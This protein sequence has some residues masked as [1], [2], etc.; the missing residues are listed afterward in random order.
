MKKLLSFITLAS[1]LLALTLPVASAG[2]ESSQIQNTV[3]EYL[4]N[5]SRNMLLYEDNQTTAYTVKAVLDD[6]LKTSSAATKNLRQY[7]FEDNK[8]LSIE[9]ILNR[10]AYVD[11]YVE[12]TKYL[13]QKQGITRDN[14]VLQYIFQNIKTSEDT[15][16]VKVK[17]WAS[18]MYTDDPL[19]NEPTEIVTSYSV[20][21]VKINSTWA[22]ADVESEYITEA[23][24]KI[25]INVSLTKHSIDTWITETQLSTLSSSANNS[26]INPTISQETPGIR[27]MTEEEASEFMS[28]FSND[29]NTAPFESTNASK[30]TYIHKT[31]LTFD[32][33]SALQYANTYW[34]DDI[35]NPDS[36]HTWRNKDVFFDYGNYG[37]DCQN[38]ASQLVYI[39]FGGTNDNAVV[40]TH[41]STPSDSTGSAI[42]YGDSRYTQNTSSFRGCSSFRNYATTVRNS[43]NESGLMT[44]TYTLASTSNPGTE[45][46]T[47]LPGSVVHVY[48]SSGNN[49]HA[50]FC[51]KT[52]G[53]TWSTVYYYSHSNSV[54]NGRIGDVSNWI[55][56]NKPIIIIK[57]TAFR[58]IVQNSCPSHVYTNYSDATCN[59]CGYNRMRIKATAPQNYGIVNLG[60]TITVGGRAVH[61]A[62]SDT[63]T[64]YSMTCY[65]MAMN[66]VTPSG[67][68]T[69]YEAL[70]VLSISKSVTF[71]E[72]GIYTFTV[73]GR[74]KNP[75]TSTDSA[76]HYIKFTVRVI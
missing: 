73:A 51:S 9:D 56:T 41:A 17:E 29:S 67:T 60:S 74:D 13:R 31:Y 7:N 75:S 63:D 6:D 37:G 34:N 50:I 5:L 52:T 39:G 1:M 8:V 2:N 48:G 23:D 69:W 45:A 61:T 71:N 25:G 46:L 53:S 27:Q 59:N 72:R 18:F 58:E 38:F 70:N 40:N 16:I 33:P 36:F 54:K 30:S 22:V 66:V 20:Y 15:A 68:S 62:T 49:S 64:M 3:E 57:P 19:N 12:C 76:G 11:D 42:W 44:R 21:M 14:L 10:I 24:K 35:D 32:L 26:S 28:A 43:T 55:G 4:T 47:D 65:R